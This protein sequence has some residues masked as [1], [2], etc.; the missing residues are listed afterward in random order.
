MIQEIANNFKL[1][2]HARERLQERF[3]TLDREVIKN[4]I[5]SN[6]LWYENTDGSYN[7]AINDWEYFVFVITDKGEPLMVTFKERSMNSVNIYEKL[8]LA[9]AG[10]GRKV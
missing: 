3:G 9:E 8:R 4:A 1:T 10:Y 5:L 7:I 6:V 2:N